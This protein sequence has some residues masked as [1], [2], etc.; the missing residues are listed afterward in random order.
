MSTS[1]AKAGYNP[2]VTQHVYLSPHLDDAV[3]SCGGLI[4][5]QSAAGESITVIT[6][7]AGDPPAGE[8][9]PFAQELH[10]RWEAEETPSALRRAEDFAACESLSARMIHLE[11]PDAVYRRGPDGAALYPD[12]ASI[13]GT[14]HESD[15]EL[16]IHI[17]GEL[18]HHVPAGA[19]LYCP[20][21]YG[22]H[23]D[24]RLARRAAESLDRRLRYY[25]D[26]PYAARG[27]QIPDELGLPEGVEQCIQLESGEIEAWLQTSSRYRSQISTF[28]TDEK[29]LR[30][31]L[32]GFHDRENGLCIIIPED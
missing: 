9:T 2:K 30:A 25:A 8:L 24:H 32:R 16:V 5:R 4:A 22:V 23:V 18:A 27:G 28:W 31:E 13:F 20:L 10:T 7:C 11:I 21:G 15:N 3:F 26:L 29:A 14:L 17:Q 1:A 6:I 12:E 19:A